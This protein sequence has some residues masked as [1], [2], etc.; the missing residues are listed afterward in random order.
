MRQDVYKLREILAPVVAAMGYE[1]V[2]VELHPHSGNALLRVYID[3]AGGI[4]VDDCQR[5]SH[6]LSGVLD[7]EDP[8][9]GPYTLEVSS[10]G[11]DRPLF[12]AQHFARFAGH[13]V[14]VQLAV[15]LNGRKTL[16]GRLVGMR[17]D[18]VVLEQHGQEVA[19]PLVG[20]E[21]A[22]LIP[23]F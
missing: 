22:R 8:L 6:Q 10:P 21:K 12:E 15:P 17:G 11:L 2:G 4:S 19:V 16:T 5:L 23:E 14:R 13:R 9:P 18:S 7:V 20:I 1:L 3:K